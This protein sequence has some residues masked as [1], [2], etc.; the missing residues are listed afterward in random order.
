LAAPCPRLLLTALVLAGATGT[1][2]AA[3]TPRSLVGQVVAVVDG[4]T[5]KVRVGDR[6]ET[7]RYIGV[8]TP[9]MRHPTRG[10]ESGAREATEAN[11][12]LVDGQTVRVELDV[13]ERDRYGRLLAYVYLGNTMVNGEM[14]GAGLR[15][16]HD[17]PAERQ[18][19]RAV[20][21]TPA[22]GPPAPDRAVARYRPAAPGTGSQRTCCEV[23]RPGH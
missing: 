2:L 1:S 5:I 4:D 3:D 17:R 11:R 16:G 20:S 7:V 21:E 8:N 12:K 13:Q 9:E 18:A 22:G 23:T 6:T 14:V 10:E 15:S 19:P